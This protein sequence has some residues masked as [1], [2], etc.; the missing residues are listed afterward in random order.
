[1]LFLGRSFLQA[2]E[3]VGLPVR[4]LM[5]TSA[6]ALVGS[7]WAAG[8]S[9]RE[10]AVEF[11]RMAPAEYLGLSLGAGGGLLSLQPVVAVLAKLVPPRFEDLPR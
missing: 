6:G 7:L 5:G 4:G 9:P 3:E 2:V 10:I 11:T 8:L 1:M